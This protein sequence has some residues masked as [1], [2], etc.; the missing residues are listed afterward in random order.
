MSWPLIIYVAGERPEPATLRLGLM[1]C[2]LSDLQ[3]LKSP[4]VVDQV[5]HLVVR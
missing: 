5:P 1:P 4:D 2:P 3:V